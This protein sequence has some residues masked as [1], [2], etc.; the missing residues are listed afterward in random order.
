MLNERL[1]RFALAYFQNSPKGPPKP[2]TLMALNGA[3]TPRDE[4]LEVFAF[5]LCANASCSARK[6][7]RKRFR[8]SRLTQ[9]CAFASLKHQMLAS[10]MS[11]QAWPRLSAYAFVRFYF[12]QMPV[13]RLGYRLASNPASLALRNCVLPRRSAYAF[14][15][16]AAAALSN[17]L[18]K[19]QWKIFCVL[20][21]FRPRGI[22]LEC[23]LMQR[24][25]DNYGRYL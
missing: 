19:C 1:K 13:A 15:Y 24:A 25:W 23:T 8:F 17:S 20:G 14:V 18:P 5:A 2:H 6:W 3:I 21:G 4:C 9:L 12:V 16:F 11:M 22:N 10:V 7:S